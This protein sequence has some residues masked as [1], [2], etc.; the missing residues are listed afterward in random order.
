M[1]NNIAESKFFSYAA[2]IKVEVEIQNI[3]LQVQTA[4]GN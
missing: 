3:R 2:D 4:K 1:H